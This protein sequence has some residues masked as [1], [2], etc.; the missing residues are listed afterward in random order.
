MCSGDFDASDCGFGLHPSRRVDYQRF[1]RAWKEI[2]Q[3]KILGCITE[4]AQAMRERRE[5]EGDTI[6][7]KVC[8]GFKGDQ[9]HPGPVGGQA[10]GTPD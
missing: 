5:G 6:P 7:P 2:E 1:L 9:L 8:A 10:A 4:R 3:Q